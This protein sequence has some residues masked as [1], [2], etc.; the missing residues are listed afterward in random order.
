MKKMENSIHMKNSIPSLDIVVPCYNEKEAFPHCLAVLGDLICNLMISK[1]V[2]QGSKI[3]FVD[4]GSKDN[5]WEL[6]KDA[7]TKNVFVR[8]IKLS[9][10]RGHQNALLAGLSESTADVVV[11]IDADLQ[12]DVS[13]IEKMIEE[14]CKGSEIVYGVRD[15]RSTDTFFKRTSANFFYS[16]MGN[17]GVNQVSNHADYR[18]MS[19][20]AVDC[21]LKFKEQNMYLRG[22]VPLLG[23][24][25]TKVYY[26]R[27]ERIAG[28]SK[29]PLGKMISLAVEGV[30]SLTTTPLKVISALGFFT[31][32]ISMIAAIYAI[33]EKINGSTVEGWASVMISIIFLGGV[34]LLCLGVIGEYIGKIYL[35]TKER[36]RFFIEEKKGNND[37]I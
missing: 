12:D 14:Y 3:I 15:D 32:L 25:S 30:T 7:C 27:D 17:M 6:I 16:I 34:Q 26:S 33:I 29:Y 10:N 21:L 18:L 4:D 9:R 37:E 22:V 35:E 13:C 11:S 5:T 8:G 24:T 36:P 2:K 1:K 28:E 20:N 19:R 31:C 23:F